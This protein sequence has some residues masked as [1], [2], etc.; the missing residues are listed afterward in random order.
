MLHLING[1]SVVFPECSM[2]CFI[3]KSLLFYYVILLLLFRID[4]HTHIPNAKVDYFVV[5]Y[6]N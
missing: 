3:W 2:F 6:C 5:R 4:A 1:P